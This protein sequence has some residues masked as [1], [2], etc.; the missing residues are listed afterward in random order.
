MRRYIRHPADIPIEFEIIDA[1]RHRHEQIHNVSQGGFA[2][3]SQA[4]VDPGR[5]ILVRIPVVEPAF[6]VR[7]RVAWCHRRAEDYDVGVEFLEQEDAYRLRMV[8][9]ICH[10]EHYKKEVLLAEGR[11]LT[12]AEAAAEW[13]G[14]F[15]AD[16]PQI[17]RK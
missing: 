7:G 9:Q 15:A 1:E 16:F 4:W 6:E 12:T 13:I 14:K 2:F 11:R 10:I 5:E 17:Q 8:E 3:Q